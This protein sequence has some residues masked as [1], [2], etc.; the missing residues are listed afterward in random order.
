M[1]N[2]FILPAFIPTFTFPAFTLSAFVF[3]TTIF[4]ISPLTNYQALFNSKVFLNFLNSK[5]FK[6]FIYLIGFFKFLGSSEPF[7]CFTLLVFVN[8]LFLKGGRHV[9]WNND[10]NDHCVFV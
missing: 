2:F 7:I 8:A 5:I 10:L 4:F 3:L 6:I 9:K 1:R